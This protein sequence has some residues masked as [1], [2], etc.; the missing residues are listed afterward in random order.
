MEVT[1][2]MLVHFL[3]QTDVFS[4]F[5]PE[6]IEAF[7]PHFEFIGVEANH[8]IFQEGSVGDGWWMILGGEVS[9]T[10]EMPSGPPHV[11]SHLETGDCFGEMS[12]LDGAPRMATLYALKD[13]QLAR[14]SREAFLQ[15]LRDREMPA[16]K[17]LWAMSTVLCRRQR[18]LTLVL[19][20]LVEVT[21]EDTVREYEILSQL[22]RS[23][24]TWH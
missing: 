2:D 24:V 12:L 16:I 7:V 10:K 8:T 14:L 13:S 3:A 1:T 6:E 22:L 9:V 15:M 21:D 5:S 18:E 17:L 4:D 23:N 20:D 19:S 11:L